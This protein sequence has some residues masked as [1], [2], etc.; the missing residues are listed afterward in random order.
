MRKVEAFFVRTTLRIESAPHRSQLISTPY[1]ST[2]K[3]FPKQP[4]Q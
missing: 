4:K 3:G 2:H 1:I